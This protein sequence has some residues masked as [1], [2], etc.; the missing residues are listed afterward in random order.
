M[1][2]LL[3]TPQLIVERPAGRGWIR[4]TR[5]D[6]PW[7]SLDEMLDVFHQIGM[8]LRR[9]DFAKLGLLVDS[10]KAAIS[11]DPAFERTIQQSVQSLPSFRRTAVLVQTVL[12]KLHTER[13]NRVAGVDG[14]VFL[15]ETEAIAYLEGP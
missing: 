4:L 12:G 1:L 5:T 8:V 2:I 11:H 9:A 14:G 13:Q 15:D 3:R 7:S 10:R 6:T